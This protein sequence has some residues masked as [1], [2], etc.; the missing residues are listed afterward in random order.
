MTGR[1]RRRPL[2]KAT[3]GEQNR[4]AGRDPDADKLTMTREDDPA[5]DGHMWSGQAAPQEADPEDDI[6]VGAPGHVPTH[7][8][9]P[10]PF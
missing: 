7:P 3:P 2:H 10:K 1:N 9:K 5:G 4:T 8:V 6:E